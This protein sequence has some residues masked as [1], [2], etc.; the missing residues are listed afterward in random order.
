[1]T[2]PDSIHTPVGRADPW[3]DQA[4]GGSATWTRGTDFAAV[5]ARSPYRQ[6]VTALY[7]ADPG[8]VRSLERTS[9][10]T[11]HLTVPELDL[12][13]ISDQLVPVQR[14]NC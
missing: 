7:R 8:A 12:H 5:L 14:E 4:A 2:E 13:T 9:V 6:E 11:G 3:I 10:P 1:M